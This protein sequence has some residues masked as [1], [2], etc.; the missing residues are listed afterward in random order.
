LTLADAC[1]FLQLAGQLGDLGFEFGQPLE[2]VPA[3]GTLRFIHAGI[4][5]QGGG[6]SPLIARER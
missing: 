2:V 4:V 3:T 5:V 1:G 6:K